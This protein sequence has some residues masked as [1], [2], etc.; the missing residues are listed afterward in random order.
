MA[1]LVAAVGSG[2][3]LRPPPPLVPLRDAPGPL[4]AAASDA[5]VVAPPPAR[6]TAAGS[7]TTGG[8]PAEPA[9][10]R[11]TIAAAVG[12]HLMAMAVL[13]LVAYLDL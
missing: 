1:D 10:P 11:L 13:G 4:K 8:A 7:D 6:S 3:G 9:R 12:L 2:G 5:S